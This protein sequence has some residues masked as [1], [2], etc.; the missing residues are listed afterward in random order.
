MSESYT[1]FNTTKTAEEYTEKKLF[2]VG[3]MPLLDTVHK[4]FPK[5]SALY[6]EMCALKWKETE[7]DFSHCLIE[8]EN[9]P[10]DMAEMMLKTLAWQ[11][12]NDSV[13][14]QAPT[15]IIAPFEPCTEAWETE[16][17]IQSNELTHGLTYSEIVRLSFKNPSKVFNDILSQQ[18]IYNRSGIIGKI[19]KDIKVFS[20]EYAYLKQ[21]GAELP[22]PEKVRE[23]LMLFYF[24]MLC[25]ERIKFM[26]SFAITF[27]ICKAG[28]FIPIGSAVMKI[29]QDELEIHSEY[30]KEMLKELM[31][32]DLGKYVFEKLKPI[33]SEIIEAV[34]DEDTAWTK[35][36]IFDND[37][38]ALI[39]TNSEII[40]QTV[41]FFAKDVVNTYK[42]KTK[43]TFPKQHPMPHLIEFMDLSK[44]QMAPMEQDIVA[45]VTQVIDV[46]DTDVKFNYNFD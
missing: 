22:P 31:A 9:A 46:N 28:Y 30:R 41:L 6:D 39:G 10:K 7:I 42:L 2:G 3:E 36:F 34:V 45:Y 4:H 33:F 25:L 38:K 40:C 23:I 17:E 21:I 32:D 8:F 27:T 35:D 18:E 20:V 15:T 44:T 5:I 12:H 37:K 16:V 11:W 19:L 29:C 26:A 13:A 24:I 43:F 14:A 1:L